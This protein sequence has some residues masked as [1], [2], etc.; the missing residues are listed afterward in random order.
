MKSYLSNFHPSIVGLTGTADEI[1]QVA[2][3]YKVYYAKVAQPELAKGYTMDHSA[4][5]YFLGKD[6]GLISVF[7]HD[8]S[9]DKMIAA[10]KPYLEK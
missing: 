4:F 6:G 7:T 2:D 8:D 10:I 1:K 3:A 9:A 5:I